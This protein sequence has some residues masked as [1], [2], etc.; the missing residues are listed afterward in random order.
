MSFGM[1]LTPLIKDQN[2]DIQ[3]YVRSFIDRFEGDVRDMIDAVQ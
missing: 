3:E 2:L 1:D